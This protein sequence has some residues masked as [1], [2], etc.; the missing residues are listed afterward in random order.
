MTI[1]TIHANEDFTLTVVAS[2]GR[3]GVFD[4]RPYLNGE[5]F[6]PL[7]DL[8]NFRKVCSRGY[9]IEWECEVD[10]SADTIESKW[11]VTDSPSTR[12]AEEPPHYGLQ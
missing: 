5:A 4:M 3:A 2:D 7:R 1:A 9:Y 6:Q 8:E 12:A 10:L 11:T